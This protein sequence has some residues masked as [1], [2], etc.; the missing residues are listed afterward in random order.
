MLPTGLGS[1][2]IRRLAAPPSL[3]L[4]L[5]LRVAV[6]NN[7]DALIAASAP[8]PHPLHDRR[9]LAWEPQSGVKTVRRAAASR[10]RFV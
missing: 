10:R 8:L 5:H 3:T 2:V 9:T 4:A 1:V 6:N 7:H